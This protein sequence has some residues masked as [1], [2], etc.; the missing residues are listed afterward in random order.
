MQMTLVSGASGVSGQAAPPSVTEARKFVFGRRLA[1]DVLAPCLR[2]G[3][4]TLL[5][6]LTGMTMVVVAVAVDNAALAGLAH[7]V[8]AKA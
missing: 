8:P 5:P 6:A 1:P 7:L 2:S 3:H 4:A